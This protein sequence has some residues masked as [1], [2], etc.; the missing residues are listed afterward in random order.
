MGQK[1]K[2]WLLLGYY[3][4]DIYRGIVSYSRQAKWQLY[5]PVF[6]HDGIASSSM[7]SIDG[8]ISLHANVPEIV[9]AIKSAKVPVVDMCIDIGL[10]VTR[11]Y[12]DD[13]EIGR[14]TAK[15]FTE[16]GFIN[17][18]FLKS[19][20]STAHE[21]IRLK[22][23]YEESQKQ[24]RKLKILEYTQNEDYFEW[25]T[26]AVSSLPYPIGIMCNSDFEADEL[27]NICLKQNISVPQQVAV[28][29]VKSDDIIGESGI[30]PISCVDA[31]CF[32]LGYQSARL[33]DS[34]MHGEQKP[35]DTLLVKPKGIIVRQSSDI[36]AVSHPQ[37]LSALKFIK[38]NFHTTIN[39]EDIV[40][41]VSISHRQ[42]TKLFKKFI[43]HSILQ[44]LTRCRL[45]KAQKMLRE[46]D[47]K[48]KEIALACGFSSSHRLNIVFHREL[49][50]SPKEFRKAEAD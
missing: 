5:R 23:F 20:N 4:H 21:N 31:N 29:G 28:I 1:K 2:V 25:L 47:E 50:I 6:F 46:G 38:E 14:M 37:I 17:L 34:L 26:K 33:L 44:E 43:G 22:G 41:H 3:E 16:R 49:N 42:L 30:I 7:G 40:R 13:Y 36:M 48:I 8:I 10:N 11:T 24:G 39:V 32:E 18:A 45:E 15:H 12:T 27:I 19:G 35:T 9:T